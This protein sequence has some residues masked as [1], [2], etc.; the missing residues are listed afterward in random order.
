MQSMI[1]CRLQARSSTWL[2]RSV[3]RNLCKFYFCF[4]PKF[5]RYFVAKLFGPRTHQPVVA[6]DDYDRSRPVSVIPINSAPS[7]TDG[8]FYNSRIRFAKLGHRVI[9]L[10]ATGRRILGQSRLAAFGRQVAITDV[11]RVG[12]NRSFSV[13]VGKNWPD[14]GT[15]CAPPDRCGDAR[16]ADARRRNDRSIRSSCL[17]LRRASSPD[18]ERTAH[19]AV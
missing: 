9:S 12:L 7:R 6:A 8:R 16:H 15:G 17:P 19:H 4:A 5:R 2:S 18:Q 13:D 3:V 1:C 11:H 10:K 14:A